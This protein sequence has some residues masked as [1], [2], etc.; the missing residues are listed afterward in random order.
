MD[1][2]SQWDHIVYEKEGETLRNNYKDLKREIGMLWV[3]RH[4]E[5][6]PVVDGALGVV[7]KS[8]DAWFEKQE[9]NTIRT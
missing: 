7:S 4:V 5:V 1:I 2:A 6:T 8:V 3:I 9:M